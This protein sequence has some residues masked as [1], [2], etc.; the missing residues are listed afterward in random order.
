LAGRRPDQSSVAR[1]PFEDAGGLAIADTERDMLA[2][3]QELYDRA[4]KLGFAQD[5]HFVFPWHGRSKR[6]D[7]TKPMASWRT[8]WRSIRKAAGLKEVRFHDGRHTAI[9]TLAEKGLP[10]WVIQAQV[11]HVAP[12]MMKTSSHIRRQALNQA[13]EALEPNTSASPVPPPTKAPVP[14]RAK[15]VMSH[16]TSQNAD[17]RGRV[18]KFAKELA[19]QVG[20]EPTTLRLTAGCSAIELLRNSAGARSSRA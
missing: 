18:V 4:A 12:E 17:G 5:D 7:P 10:D 19:P 6:L 15:R 9:T 14:M 13:A 8:A 1:P 3:L 11:G 20:L 16:S 2:R